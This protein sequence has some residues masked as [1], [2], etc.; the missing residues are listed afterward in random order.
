MAHEA[1]RSILHETE[2]IFCE[3]DLHSLVETIRIALAE[4]L[5]FLFLF[6]LI[7][8]VH[9]ITYNGGK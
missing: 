2:G 1:S 5:S 3:R 8:C 9:V 4:Y 7:W 6:C